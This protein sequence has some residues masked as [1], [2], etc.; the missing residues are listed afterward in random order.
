MRAPVAKGCKGLSGSLER[1]VG[2]HALVGSMDFS[3][4]IVWRDADLEASE[5]DS[6]RES[7]G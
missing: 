7:L 2:S 6:A 3:T 5:G 4:W 1:A